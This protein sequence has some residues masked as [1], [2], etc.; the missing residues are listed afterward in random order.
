MLIL[1]NSGG[2]IANL[3]LGNDSSGLETVPVGSVFHWPVIGPWGQSAESSLAFCAWN[4]A[5]VKA[6]RSRRSASFVN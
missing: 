1:T 6:P 5:S 4:S 3:I 2:T